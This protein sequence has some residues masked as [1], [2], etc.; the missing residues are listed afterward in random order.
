MPLS[1]TLLKNSITKSVR[2]NELWLGN[3][4]EHVSYVTNEGEL[5]DLNLISK[6]K[7]KQFIWNN[8]QLM[9]VNN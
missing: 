5:L 6:N 1:G 2:K 4:A 8:N 7:V 9:K 3:L